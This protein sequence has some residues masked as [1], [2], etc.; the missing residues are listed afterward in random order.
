MQKSKLVSVLVIVFLSL[1]FLGCT[2]EG[3]SNGEI[4]EEQTSADNV[5]TP[6]SPE[7]DV[8]VYNATLKKTAI[9][10]IDNGYSLK[11][12]EINRKEGY[13]ILSLRKDGYEY[14]TKKIFV[15]RS[16]DVWDPEKQFIVYS[17]KLESIYD[18]SFVIDLS[19]TLKPEIYLYVDFPDRDSERKPTVKIEKDSITRN[20][21]WE[22]DDRQ[23]QLQARYDKEAYE[24]YSQ[25]TRYRHWV[26]FVNDPYDDAFISQI[27]LQ[28][29][30]LAEEADY[31]REEI[32][33][34]TML[35]V[36]S[37]PYVSDSVSAG[38]DE[39]PRFPFET[40]YHGGGDCEDSSILLAALLY[41]MGYGVSLI[42]LPGHMAVG[43]KGSDDLPG[44]YYDYSG[45]K[46]FYL[47]TTN[48]GWE[49]GRIP[50]VYRN[51]D[52]RIIPITDGYPEIAVD[53][54]GSGRH[55][56]RFSYI[57]LD[58]EVENVGSAKAEDVIIYTGL[59][60]TQKGMVWD[61]VAS[62]QIP[63]ID[64]E[65]AVSYEISNLK[66]PVGETYRIGIRVVGSNTGVEYVY[67]DWHVS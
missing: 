26:H 45:V 38:Y 15:G 60:A 49:V 50:T 25:R 12:L 2:E 53:F 8:N 67:S 46:Y 3:N 61:Q 19:Y 7:T 52:A 31:G 16:Y 59:E 9:L 58:I 27:T 40:M 35:F 28:M 10:D 34:I 23:F 39:Y 55:D 11:V 57:D 5:S 65:E 56:S 32:P 44:S 63:E 30:N 54:A 37:L 18:N 29:E 22:Y 17:I 1:S 36:Q 48:S 66:V 6:D 62:D 4:P 42:E 20:Y 64:V 14:G 33:Y 41:D 51:S 43:V 47:E 21:V 24:L 13:S